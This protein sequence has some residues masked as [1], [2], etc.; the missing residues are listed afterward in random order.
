[1]FLIVNS[2]FSIEKRIN[3]SAEDYLEK[4]NEYA[5]GILE[6]TFEKYRVLLQEQ[7]SELIMSLESPDKKQSELTSLSKV[8][9]DE[10]EGIFL[11]DSKGEILQSVSFNK[12]EQPHLDEEYIKRDTSLPVFLGNKKLQNSKEYFLNGFYYVNFYIYD[13]K[14]D[15]T[16]VVPINLQA[17]YKNQIKNGKNNYHGYSIV[18]NKDMVV[19]MH[20]SNNQINLNITKDRKREYPNFDFQGLE[21][22][23]ETQ[24]SQKEGTIYY[25]SYWWDQKT[26]TEAEKLSVF[27]WVNMGD[28][29]WVV[30]TNSDI[31]ERK[32]LPLANVLLLLVIFII[33]VIIFILFI[34][35]LRQ[36]QHQYKVYL[37]YKES[38]KRREEDQIRHDLEKKIQQESK[39]ETIGIVSTTIVHDLNN[40]LTPLLGITKLMMD[41][42]QDDE[43]LLSDLESIYISAKKGQELSSNILRFS[44]LDSKEKKQAD[45]EEV[46]KDGVKTIRLLIPKNVELVLDIKSDNYPQVTMEPQDLQN[47]LFNLITNA[48]QAI[49]SAKGK[50]TISMF[51]E[52]E[53][54][55]QFVP[56]HFKNKQVVVVRVMDD[57]P[58]IPLEIQDKVLVTPFYTTKDEDGGT[59]LGL[60]VVTSLA[61]KYGWDVQ[62]YSGNKG[63]SF[64]IRIPI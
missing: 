34:I 17:L 37:K 13:K 32:G 48:Y 20:P 29:H 41:E 10:I 64:F 19:I 62:L 25:D 18:K 28:S 4:T 43:A 46:I 7:S 36:Y 42:Y 21:K 31:K 54:S 6:Q 58:G 49:G 53:D 35:I 14:N 50:I 2:Y 15:K 3:Q 61:K 55:Q 26:P 16:L 47:V 39:L 1:M 63:T 57:G 40:I 5:I 24:L 12:K 27:K 59:G 9:K 56:A 8:A 51:K 60:F 22:V 44:K 33:I 23:E 52:K 30:S 11:M 45:L 38:E